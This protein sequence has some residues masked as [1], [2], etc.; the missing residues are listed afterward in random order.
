[1]S[2]ILSAATRLATIS[3]TAKLPSWLLGMSPAHQKAYLKEHPDSPFANLI[4]GAKVAPVTAPVDTGGAIP[5]T[6]KV[7]KEASQP[8]KLNGDTGKG[9]RFTAAVAEIGFGT[10]TKPLTKPVLDRLLLKANTILDVKTKSNGKF[11]TACYIINIEGKWYW[12]DTSVEDVYYMI[13]RG[14]KVDDLVAA[15]GL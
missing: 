4:G 9:A 7:P 3:A 13:K 14:A 11:V 10:V 5:V 2:K 6:Y 12:M 1:M 8:Y 15:L